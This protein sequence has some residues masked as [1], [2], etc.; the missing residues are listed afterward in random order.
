MYEVNSTGK[1]PHCKTAA[2]FVDTSDR[3]QKG[4]RHGGIST[5]LFA[6]SQEETVHVYTSSCPECHKPIAV[7][8]RYDAFGDFV[9]ERVVYPLNVARIVPSEV[10]PDIGKDF[11][12]ASTVLPISEKASTALSRR[13]LQNVLSENGFK[14][15]DLN[16]QIDDARALQPENQF[17]EYGYRI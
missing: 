13:C 7:L 15:K 5:Q 2:C 9:E 14:K 1:R 6:S 4:L 17:R 12:E 8:R 10:P 16:D 11:S 3:D